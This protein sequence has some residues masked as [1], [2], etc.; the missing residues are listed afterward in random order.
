MPITF[1]L[2]MS[3]QLQEIDIVLHK[4]TDEIVSLGMST[5]SE[6]FDQITYTKGMQELER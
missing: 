6:F 3:P 5:S 1:E 2:P 4:A